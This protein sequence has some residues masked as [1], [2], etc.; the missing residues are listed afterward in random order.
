MEKPIKRASSSNVKATIHIAFGLN[1]QSGIYFRNTIAVIDEICTNTE[2]HVHF[3]IFHDQTITIPIQKV[4]ERVVHQYN[5]DISFLDV[6]SQPEFCEMHNGMLY[7]LF[8]PRLCPEVDKMIYLD[9]DILVLEDIKVLWEISIKEYAIAAVLDL[10]YTREAFVST[11]YYLRQ[12]IIPKLYFNSGVLLMNLGYIRKK[13]DLPQD[14]LVFIKNN[15]YTLMLDQDFLNLKFQKNTLLLPDKFNYICDD[16]NVA[17]QSDLK[18]KY[19]VHSAGPFK[20]W[21]CRNP[22]VLNYFCQHYA[23]NFFKEERESKLREYMSMLPQRYFDRMGLKHS[24]LQHRKSVG[25]G[26]QILLSL[27]CMVKA[28]CNDTQY[29]HFARFIMFKLRLKILYSFFYVYI[30]RN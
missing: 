13:C 17:S 18:E 14:Y 5:Q 9:S 19:I 24:L 10:A 26:Q 11:K 16:I 29:I 22:F 4:F 1:D 8:I 21:N 30:K 15:P 20:P 28:L 3:Y 6:T 7:R 25:G 12:G 27:A 2:S 23:I